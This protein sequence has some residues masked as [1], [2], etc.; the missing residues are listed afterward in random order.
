MIRQSITKP[1]STLSERLAGSYWS[2]FCGNLRSQAHA[3]MMDRSNPTQKE[4]EQSG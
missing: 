2:G 3:G 1:V 4:N